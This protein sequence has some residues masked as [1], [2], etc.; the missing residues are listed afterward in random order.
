MRYLQ[1]RAL[2]SRFHGHVAALR[3]L[4][5]IHG[6]P[7]ERNMTYDTRI[8]RSMVNDFERSK[9]V[10]RKVLSTLS[11]NKTTAGGF[12]G[13]VFEGSAPCYIASS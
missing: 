2:P 3:K 13:D 7:E 8:N 1:A 10:E 12:E 4:C 11:A 6:D 9:V 5:V